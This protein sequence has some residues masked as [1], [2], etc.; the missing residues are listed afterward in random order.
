MTDDRD[1]SDSESRSPS[2]CPHCGQSLFGIAVFGPG[3]GY[4]T[5]CGCRVAP[6]LLTDGYGD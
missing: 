4:A 6:T 5:P 3:E 2:D 1:S